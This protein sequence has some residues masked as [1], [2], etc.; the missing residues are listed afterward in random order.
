MHARTLSS[1][2]VMENLPGWAKWLPLWDFLS[3]VSDAVPTCSPCYVEVPIL[4]SNPMLG[5]CLVQ[6]LGAGKPE[7]KSGV[8]CPAE[9]P[10]ASGTKCLCPNLLCMATWEA[11]PNSEEVPRNQVT[12]SKRTCLDFQVDVTCCS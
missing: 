7:P 9:V 1:L 6:L 10:G 8:A 4:G 5:G 2:C 11:T 3:E 12:S